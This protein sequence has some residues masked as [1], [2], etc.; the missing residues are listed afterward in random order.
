MRPSSSRPHLRLVSAVGATVAA[1]ALLAGCASGSTAQV[2]PSNSADAVTVDNCGTEVTFESA[3]ERVV[4]IKST[5]TE[6]LLAL[7][8]A[9]RIVGSAFSDGPVPE[10]WA[11]AAADVPVLSEQ[12]P[13]NEAVLELNPDLVYAGW[14]SN[15]S[16][17]GAGDRDELESL[18]VHTYVAP[19]ACKEPGY[20]PERLSF[21][22]VFGE[23]REIGSVFRV[24]DAAEAL[25]AEQQELLDAIEPSTAGLTALWYS[26]GTDAPYVGAGIGA[27]QLVLDT[28]GLENVAASVDDT[29]TTLGWESVVEADPDVIVL[30]DADWNTAESKIS[31]LESNPAT[32]QLDAVRE[33]RYL[34]IDFAASEAGVR[35][36]TAAADLADQLAALDVRG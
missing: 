21:D 11:D 18:G 7:G 2:P 6:M 17:E 26:S 35:T 12:V 16:A 15:L 1:T 20:Q 30:V 4:T 23:I 29:W 32:A 25:V 33:K 28:V 36:V 31:N 9:D 8:L 10:E 5:S 19:A 34:T 27:P 13:S 14:E 22:D 3:P 24:E